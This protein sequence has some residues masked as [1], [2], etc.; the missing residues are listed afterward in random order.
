MSMQP[1]MMSIV[2]ILRRAKQRINK[3]QKWISYWS[4]SDDGKR[5][6]A[7]HAVGWAA[8]C[9]D[10]LSE[11]SSD[12]LAALK[13]LAAESGINPLWTDYERVAYLNGGRHRDVMAA[14]DRAI[15][16]LER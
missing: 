12:A 6:C 4:V 5:L 1:L 9:D 13:A 2:D 16:R 3:P 11:F 15:Q 7:A 14:F 10:S 8:G